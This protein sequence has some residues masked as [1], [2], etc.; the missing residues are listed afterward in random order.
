MSTEAQAGVR[1]SRMCTLEPRC[2]RP[3]KHV[4]RSNT[5]RGSFVLTHYPCDVHLATA[6]SIG[7][8]EIEPAAEAAER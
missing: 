2:R 1:P 7:W 6:L 3:A 5:R 8:H 4:V